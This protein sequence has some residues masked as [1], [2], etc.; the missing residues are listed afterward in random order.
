MQLPQFLGRLQSAEQAL[1]I[2]CR[3]VAEQHHDEVDVVATA[4]L[5]A[6]QSTAHLER[7][8]PFTQRYG[9]A[10]ARESEQIRAEL[11][12]PDGSLGLLRDLSGLALLVSAVSMSWTVLGQAAKALRD[13]EL[14]TLVNECSEET[15]IQLEWL[16][17]RIKAAAPQIL[18]ASEQ[19][20]T[21]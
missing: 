21:S 3:Q 10:G 2:G 18:I 16:Q 8:K 12:K 6:K 14:Q 19:R 5:F 4:Q 13:Q 9:V 15:T 7:L 1:Q 20:E 17:T 11:F